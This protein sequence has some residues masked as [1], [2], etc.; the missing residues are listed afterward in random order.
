MMQAAHKL[1]NDAQQMLA[2]GETKRTNKKGTVDGGYPRKRGSKYY[3]H[4][5][6]I[7]KDKFRKKQP[8]L[9]TRTPTERRKDRMKRMKERKLGLRGFNDI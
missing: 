5:R 3:V 2:V 6:C 7:S 9:D 4:Q 1:P 8:T